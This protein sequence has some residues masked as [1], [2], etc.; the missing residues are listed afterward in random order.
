MSA[1]ERKQAILR[2]AAP[3]IAQNGLHGVSI[4]D[5]AVAAGVSE[6]LLYKHF[7]SKQ[8]IYDEALAR[9]REFSR[10]TIS[11]FATLVPGIESFVLLT[12]ATVTFTLFGFPGREDHAQGAARLVFQSLLGDGE[13]ARTIFADTAAN[14]M[15]YVL[16]SFT[17]AVASGDIVDNGV[18][19]ANRFRFVQQFGMALRLSHLPDLPAF[20]YRGTQGELANQAVLFS[21]RGVGVTDEAIARHFQ[22]DSLQQQLANFF[23][24]RPLSD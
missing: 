16:A 19:P 5:I 20:R 11:R 14:W 10:L 2:A 8:A 23:S 6:A 9:A 17:A 22:P 13:Y 18:E 4:R 15:D 1:D 12:Y 7:P 24:D 21:L 3:V